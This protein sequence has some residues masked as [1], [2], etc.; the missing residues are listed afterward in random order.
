MKKTKAQV[1]FTAIL[2]IFFTF[3]VIYNVKADTEEFVELL[4]QQQTDVEK[5]VVCYRIWSILSGIFELELND[6]NKTTQESIKTLFQTKARV[7]FLE[8]LSE[9]HGLNKLMNSGYAAGVEMPIV[10]EDPLIIEHCIHGVN[11]LMFS[12]AY[13]DI[14]NFAFNKAEQYVQQLASD[15]KIRGI[16]TL[17]E[18]QRKIIR[19][20]TAANGSI[21]KE[22]HELFWSEMA[23]I[24]INHSEVK[25]NMAWFSESLKL[26]ITYQREFW[27][28][29]LLSYKLGEAVTT[30]EFEEVKLLLPK[31]MRL[32]F[33]KNYYTI[34][35]I[36]L[37]K[38]SSD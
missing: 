12:T 14:Q 5:S 36:M 16:N 21:T 33:Q 8:R 18:I 13:T 2:T 35:L 1:L 38:V 10:S 11:K 6:D 15:G 23:R 3:P 22:M 24:G 29:M 30:S 26:A 20:V 27:K 19:E 37:T 9:E 17:T 34:H 4:K 28:S 31:V 7:F 25:R 32:E